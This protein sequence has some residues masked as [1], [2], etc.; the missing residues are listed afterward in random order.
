MR[1]SWREPGAGKGRVMAARGTKRRVRQARHGSG[2][3]LL[4]TLIWALAACASGASGGTPAPTRVAQAP[5]QQ[6]L[7]LDVA[8]L[9]LPAP[10]A[11]SRPIAVA[12]YLSTDEGGGGRA[13]TKPQAQALVRE[14]VEGASAIYAQ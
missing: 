4:A 11:G 1:R 12:L 2:G 13:W 6:L 5:I 7:A 3:I 14:L 9:E 10:P 8:A